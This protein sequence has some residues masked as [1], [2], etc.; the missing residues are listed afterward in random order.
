[1]TCPTFT[2]TQRAMMHLAVGRFAQILKE[3]PVEAGEHKIGGRR[4]VLDFDQGSAV[5]RDIGNGEGVTIEPVQVKLTYNAV[6]L[7]ID[8]A[9]H[10][11]PANEEEIVSL[12]KMCILDDMRGI[13]ASPPSEA[14]HAV[15]QVQE[16]MLDKG[17]TVEA[18]TQARR[19]GEK[20]IRISFAQSEGKK[21]R[22]KS[23]A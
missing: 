13:E 2:P 5:V 20:R 15:A 18:K 19:F 3:H 12:W 17:E 23:A 9:A 7:F 16:I 10:Q 1:M 4:L 8:R 11:P 22:R 21:K 6:L 14:I